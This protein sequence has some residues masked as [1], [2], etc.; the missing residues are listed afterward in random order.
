MDDLFEQSQKDCVQVFAYQTTIFVCTHLRPM[1]ITAVYQKK[2][3]SITLP[4][5][6]LNLNDSNWIVSKVQNFTVHF[7]KKGKNLFN[8]TVY[9]IA[10]IYT[11]RDVLGNTCIL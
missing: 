4:C 7:K 9:I 10:F 8:I 3:R 5:S 2:T 11:P 6:I 1:K